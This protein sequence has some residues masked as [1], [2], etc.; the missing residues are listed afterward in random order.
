MKNSRSAAPVGVFDSG[1]GGIS[2]LGTLTRVMPCE[3]FIYYGD[4]ANA[5]YGEKTTEEVRTIAH[6]VVKKLLDMG[7]KAIVIACNTATS[8]AA[9]SLRS[10]YPDV[11][12]IGM[13]PAVKPAAL[14]AEHPKVLV[15]AT[16]LTIRETKLRCLMD[17]YRDRADFIEVPCHGLVELIERGITEGCEMDALLHDILM[18]HL[19]SCRIDAAVLGCTHYIHV[20]DSIRSILGGSVAIFDGALGTARET[21]NRLESAGIANT[22]G[23]EGNVQIYNSR[24]DQNLLG[25]SEKLFSNAKHRKD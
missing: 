8:A 6:G 3:N 16:P 4:S 10:T 18:P 19:N 25:L 12:I 7:A 17:R 14:S 2:V 24:D 15:M 13:E 5:P 20:K 11:P 23:A 21:L 22:S 9:E 1:V